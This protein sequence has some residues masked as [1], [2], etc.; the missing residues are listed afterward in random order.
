MNAYMGYCARE[1][2]S[3]SL[4]REPTMAEISEKCGIPAEEL[5]EECITRVQS[6]MEHPFGDNVELNLPISADADS[7]DS[8][9][10]AK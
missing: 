5:V 3:L 9:Q 8:Y 4:G 2:L 1:E 10:E 7:G 6:Y